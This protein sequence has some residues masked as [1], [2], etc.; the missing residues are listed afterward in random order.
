MCGQE[1]FGLNSELV[2]LPGSIFLCKQLEDA[3]RWQDLPQ[4]QISPLPTILFGASA[5]TKKSSDD[6]TCI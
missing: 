4:E 3:R 6:V 2:F 5:M 1:M